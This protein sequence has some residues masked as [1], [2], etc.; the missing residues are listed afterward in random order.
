MLLDRQPGQN[1]N[2]NYHLCIFHILYNSYLA[3]RLGGIRQKKCIIHC[4]ASRWF[5]LFYSPKPRSQGLWSIAK[6]ISKIFRSFWWYGDNKNCYSSSSYFSLP[7]YIT[8][9][10]TN[11]GVS[12]AIGKT[13][14]TEL[15][16]MALL[17]S[18][19]ACCTLIPSR[20]IPSTLSNWSPGST[21]PNMNKK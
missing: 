17:S 20:L 7:Q 6:G 19:C 16:L 18:S 2:I 10:G 15:L 3:P 11:E 21:P 14:P 4:W 9:Q 1:G 5:L 12:K 13:H 8:T